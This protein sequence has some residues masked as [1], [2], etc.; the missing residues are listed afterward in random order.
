MNSGLITSFVI[1]GLLLISILYMQMNIS[2]S[3]TKLTMSQISQQNVDTVSDL[4]SHDIQKVGFDEFSTID[5][6]IIIADS[7]QLRFES[8]LDNSGATEIVEWI[9]DQ[10][11]TLASSTNPNAHLLIRKVDGNTTQLPVGVTNFKF[12]Y[13]NS[14]KQILP[15]PV[16]APADIRYIK[17]KLVVSSKEK[18]GKMG[19]GE[20]EYVKSYW[21]KTFSPK[22]LGN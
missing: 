8:N 2:R 19:S 3:S 22:N 7:S 1:G 13:L 14:Q 10:S 9:Y 4:L 15:T 5:N 12:T 11:S 21:E 17:V 18:L 20:A 16:S 6:P